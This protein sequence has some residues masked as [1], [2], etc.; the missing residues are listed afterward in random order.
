MKKKLKLFIAS[1]L[2][3]GFATV[4]IAAC[5]V[6]PDPNLNPDFDK[7]KFELVP[8]GISDYKHY[9]IDGTNTRRVR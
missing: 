9:W 6:V 5:A 4:G 7:S 2:F 8:S 1:L 3:G